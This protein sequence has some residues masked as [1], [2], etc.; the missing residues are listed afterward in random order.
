MVRGEQMV[1]GEQCVMMAGIWLRQQWCVATSTSLMP[2]LRL[3][4]ECMVEVHFC[5]MLFSH[6]N[7]TQEDV[8]K[9]AAIYQVPKQSR[10]N[11]KWHDSSIVNGLLI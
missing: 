6:A 3:L 5:N 9:T 8:V 7:D 11:V 1:S 2:N 10:Y 4:G